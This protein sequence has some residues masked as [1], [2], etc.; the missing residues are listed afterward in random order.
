MPDVNGLRVKWKMERKLLSDTEKIT[1]HGK[2]F[3]NLSF[4]VKQKADYS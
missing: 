4:V 3:I 2:I 1:A